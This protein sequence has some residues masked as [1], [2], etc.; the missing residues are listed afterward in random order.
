[1]SPPD[2]A[3][4]SLWVRYVDWCSAQVAR[5]L[6][7]LSPEELW[8]RADR[9]AQDEFGAGPLSRAIVP[10]ARQLAVELYEELDLPP[11]PRWSEEYRQDPA[12]FDPDI[13]GFQ[14]PAAAFLSGDEP[15]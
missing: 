12:R 11:Y 3:H 5:R 14:A 6:L 1:M 9:L 8:Q 10:L 4:G 13:L 7:E 15:D 2:A